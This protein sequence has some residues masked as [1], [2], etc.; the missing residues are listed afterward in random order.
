MVVDPSLLRYFRA[1]PHLVQSDSIR[2][3]C[4]EPPLTSTSVVLSPAATAAA[5]LVW[6]TECFASVCPDYQL[7]FCSM[8]KVKLRV[9]QVAYAAERPYLLNSANHAHALELTQ[10]QPIV[11]GSSN[12]F[13]RCAVGQAPT[14]ITSACGAPITSTSRVSAVTACSC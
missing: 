4:V 5:L 13:A 9:E 1:I 10:A 2:T 12:A 6:A 14:S 11:S 8:Q 7:G 3:M